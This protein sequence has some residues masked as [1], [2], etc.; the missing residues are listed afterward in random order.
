MKTL[1][2]SIVKVCDRSHIKTQPTRECSLT[3]TKRMY[4][5]VRK[6]AKSFD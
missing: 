3:I 5:F 6:I 2:K 4:K 1:N